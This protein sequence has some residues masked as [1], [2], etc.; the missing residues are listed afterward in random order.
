MDF[1][2]IVSR[3]GE[4]GKRKEGGGGLMTAGPPPPFL[5]QVRITP[6]VCLRSESSFQHRWDRRRA[7]AGMHLMRPRRGSNEDR[8]LASRVKVGFA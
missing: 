1:E 2:S 8:E 6:S 3:V 4:I 5:P 7:C